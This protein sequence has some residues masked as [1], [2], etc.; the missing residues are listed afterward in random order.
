[1][2]KRGFY[3]ILALAVAACGAD[4]GDTDDAADMDRIGQ[5]AAGVIDPAAPEGSGTLRLGA[6]THAF[7][8]RACDVSGDVDD[9]YQTLSGRGQTELGENFDVFVSRSEAAGV[10]VHTVSFQ[11]GDVATGRG[12]VLEAQRMRHGDD[13]I[14]TQGGPAE[15]LIE[16]DGQSITAS[17]IFAS[18]DGSGAPVQGELEATCRAN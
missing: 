2:Q 13:W 12:T 8:V 6:D 17:G 11:Q 3:L 7:L 15:P 18:P 16:I 4:D 14:S 1:M 10:L 5:E 9:I